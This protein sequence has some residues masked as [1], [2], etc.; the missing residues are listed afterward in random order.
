MLVL[1]DHGIPEY[2]SIKGGNHHGTM[3]GVYRPTCLKHD[4]CDV[5]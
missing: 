2:A 1:T 4:F 5:R 3:K